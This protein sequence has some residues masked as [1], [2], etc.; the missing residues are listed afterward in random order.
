VG[1]C[2]TQSSE[3]ISW[4]FGDLH[5]AALILKVVRQFDWVRPPLQ[6]CRASSLQ[7]IPLAIEFLVS[8]KLRGNRPLGSLLTGRVGAAMVVG[9]RARAWMR[10]NVR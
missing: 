5:L 9:S 6:L 2:S 4:G 1:G 7:R 10:V 8:R 3:E